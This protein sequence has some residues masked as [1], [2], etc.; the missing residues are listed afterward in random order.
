MNILNQLSSLFS[1]HEY[2]AVQFTLNSPNEFENLAGVQ[3]KVISFKEITD[4]GRFWYE[5]KAIVVCKNTKKQD[6]RGLPIYITETGIYFVY[7][8]C[9]ETYP[10]RGIFDRPAEQD[11]NDIATS[12]IGSNQE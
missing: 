5:Q 9:E 12:N 2:R 4:Y 10:P 1:P 8:Y 7:F 11:V 6:R 3:F